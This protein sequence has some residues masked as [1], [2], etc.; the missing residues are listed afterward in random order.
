MITWVNINGFSQN[1]VCALILWR[2]GLELLKGKFCQILTELSPK[3]CPYCFSMKEI[4]FEIVYEQIS[5]TFDRVIC[6][7]HDNGGVLYFNV[8][9]FMILFTGPYDCFSVTF[10]S[11]WIVKYTN[12]FFA[13]HYAHLKADP[14]MA[15][16]NLSSA[17]NL[18]YS[19]KKTCLYNFDPLKPHFYIV[20]LG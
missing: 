10:V 3:T 16:S 11:A 19:I 12:V 6:P 18:S 7:R 20:K 2:S 14:A 1:L 13:G 15:I 9:I 8:F 4:W 5:S 17:T